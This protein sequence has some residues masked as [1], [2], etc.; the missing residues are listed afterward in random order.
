MAIGTRHAIIVDEN[1]D[2]FGTG[3][4]KFGQLGLATRQSVN[5]FTKL[6]KND[7]KI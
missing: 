2:V 3:D 4:N 6:N 5:K 1:D 7:Q